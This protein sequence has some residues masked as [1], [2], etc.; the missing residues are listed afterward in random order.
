MSYAIGQAVPWPVPPDWKR[1]VREQLE[2]LT[3]ALP[4]ARSGKQ[5]K[6]K[7]RLAPRRRFSFEVISEALERRIADAVRF[8]HA[9]RVWLLPIWPDV[10]MLTA[11]LAQDVTAIACRTTGFDFLAG[12]RAMLWSA[13]NSFEIVAIDSLDEEGLTL[14]AP[15]TQ[16]WPRGTR[17]Y[18]VRQARLQ[19]NTSESHWSD[20]ASRTRVEFAID[21]PS[22]WSIELAEWVTSTYRDKPV[23]EWRPDEPDDPRSSYSRELNELDEGTGPVVMSDLPDM[24]FR[25]QENDWLIGDREQHTAFRS[26]LYMLSGRFGAMWVPSWNADLKLVSSIASGATEMTVEWCGYT[27]F[28]REQVNRKDIRIELFDGT[29]LYRRITDS[30]ESGETEVLTIDS[31][32][33]QAIAP[34]A[35]RVISFLTYA[36]L[37]SDAVEIS[38]ITDA[39]GTAR[40]TLRFDGIAHDL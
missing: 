21:E 11:D 32:P 34:A 40:A 36:Q 8:D 25:S 27:V 23:L 6:R 38:H 17:L 14:V 10:Q 20:D 26:L 1:P 15:T 28:G 30:S 22:D 39:D 18:P 9:S 7:L 13:P 4:R 29:V 3:D 33:G 12:G 31:A 35:V 16:A 24:P 19:P 2:W 5:Q 37:A